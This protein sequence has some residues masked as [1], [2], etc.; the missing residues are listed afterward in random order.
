V[1]FQSRG[2]SLLAAHEYRS[3]PSE[4]QGPASLPPPRRARVPLVLSCK[5]C[6]VGA[7]PGSWV[8]PALWEPVGAGR[9]SFIIIA[10]IKVG[11]RSTIQA[12]SRCNLFPASSFP[13]KV[14]PDFLLATFSCCA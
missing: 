9:F 6:G 2:S 8:A 3:P 1:I 12:Q 4:K 11:A 10:R 7:G 5:S 14:S 13:P